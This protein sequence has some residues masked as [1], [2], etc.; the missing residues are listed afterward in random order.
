MV[1][2]GDGVIFDARLWHGSSGGFKDRRLITLIY[3]RVP[4][5]ADEKEATLYD[6]KGSRS[7]RE[8][9]AKNT[10]ESPG[11]EYHHLW[12]SEAQKDDRRQRWIDWMK[13][14]GYMDK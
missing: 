1:N 11:P 13:E 3:N 2:P 14:F 5:S 10:Y 4:E 8:N 12:L 7:T 6:V 9:L